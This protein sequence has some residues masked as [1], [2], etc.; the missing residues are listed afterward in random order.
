MTIT[1]D[2]ETPSEPSKPKIVYE[3]RRAAPVKKSLWE[4]IKEE[5]KPGAEG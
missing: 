2:E 3:E 1:Y 5:A 4:T